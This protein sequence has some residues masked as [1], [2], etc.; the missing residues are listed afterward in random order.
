MT[1]IYSMPSTNCKT[2]RN[3]KNCPELTGSASDYVLKCSYSGIFLL[4]YTQWCGSLASQK[5]YF[6]QNIFAFRRD[7]WNFWLILWSYTPSSNF[8]DR[9]YLPQIDL[10][11]W[12]DTIEID[13]GFL[14][15]IVF[16]FL[17]DKCPASW[18]S[19]ISNCIVYD[20]YKINIISSRFMRDRWSQN[21]ISYAY[22]IRIEVLNPT[23]KT[24]QTCL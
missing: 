22:A 8:T 7:N 19:V 9:R 17:L 24:S 1:Q 21:H 10:Q 6:F 14:W 23:N 4:P 16:V 11:I 3:G 18:Y 2:I 15:F 20:D 12:V 13:R 5:S